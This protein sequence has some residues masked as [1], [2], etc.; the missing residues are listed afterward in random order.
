MAFY[1][2]AGDGRFEPTELTRGPWTAGT[3]HAGPPAALLGR[4]IEQKAPPDLRV[5]RVTFD[6]ARPVPI[7]P[8]EVA[9]AVVR[10][11][12]SVVVI[13]PGPTGGATARAGRCRD[14]TVL[15]GAADTS[16]A[17]AVVGWPPYLCLLLCTED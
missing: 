17:G 7:A 14:Q 4:A 11:G 3:Q 9:T 10:E 6:I 8:L 16:S 1:L 5:A 12:R 13:E 15:P 2:P